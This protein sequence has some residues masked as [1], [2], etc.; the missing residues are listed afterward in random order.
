[1]QC[2]AY[3]HSGF[4]IANKAIRVWHGATERGPCTRGD[5]RLAASL[6]SLNLRISG[7][8]VTAAGVTPI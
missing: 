4:K 1:V 5:A 2:T 8:N 6:R 7:T 3:G